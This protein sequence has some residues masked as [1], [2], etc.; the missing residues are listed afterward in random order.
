MTLDEAR[1]AMNEAAAH[2]LHVD[3]TEGHAAAQR[4]WGEYKAAH[5]RYV[6]A[7]QAEGR[8]DPI[9]GRERV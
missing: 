1:I 9:T 8:W 2:A 5:G 4:E 3:R 6:L 7:A